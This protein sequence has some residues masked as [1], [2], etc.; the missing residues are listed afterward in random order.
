MLVTSLYVAL[1]GVAAF[2]LRIGGLPETTQHPPTTQ[3]RTYRQPHVSM[4]L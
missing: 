4:S 1:C 3:R 2:Q